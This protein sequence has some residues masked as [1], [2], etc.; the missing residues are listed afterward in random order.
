VIRTIGVI[1]GGQ[2]GRMFALDA[3]RMGYDVIALDP[4]PRSPCGQIADEQIVAQYDDFEA[5]ERLGSCTDV[6]TYEFENIAIESIRRLEERGFAV[7]PG[8]RALRCT[9]DRIRDKTF[10]PTAAAQLSPLVD[11]ADL[12]GPF[13]TRDDPFEGLC[14]ANGKLVLPDGP[15]IGVR[16]RK[17][18]DRSVGT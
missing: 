8:S 7:P 10:A 9:R 5:I 15:G 11:W 2:L 3:K 1:G 17:T 18:A 13:L 6:V 14:Y 4:Q 16:A 12:D